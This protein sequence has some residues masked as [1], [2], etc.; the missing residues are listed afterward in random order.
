[1]GTSA[2][3]QNNNGAGYSYLG[4]ASKKDFSSSSISQASKLAP[5]RE[6]QE[7]VKS[8]LQAVKQEIAESDAYH[9]ELDV[10]QADL[11]LMRMASMLD[12]FKEKFVDEELTEIKDEIID[13]ISGISMSA[14]FKNFLLSQV[15]E[16]FDTDA[17]KEDIE[18]LKVELSELIKQNGA[19]SSGGVS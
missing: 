4:T 12:E 15:T 17:K 5:K 9:K 10:K 8:M 1:M 6:Q 11:I 16:L 18:N 2:R 19:G 13:E 3:M 7:L 14:I